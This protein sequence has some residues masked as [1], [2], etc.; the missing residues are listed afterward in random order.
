MMIARSFRLARTAL[1]MAGLVCLTTVASAGIHDMVCVLMPQ[2]EVPPNGSPN[3]TGAGVFKIDTTANT[4]S[5]YIVVGGLSAAETAAHIHGAAN[6]GVNAGVLQPLAVGTVKTGVWNYAQ[7][8][9]ADILAG[10]MYVN[11]H[12]TAFPGGEVRGQIVTHVA[13]LDSAQE[14]PANPSTARG[15]GLITLDK[16]AKTLSYYIVHNVAG[17]TAAHFHGFA[18]HGVNAGVSIAL[19]VGSPKVGVAPYVA[20]DEDK[21][22]DGL[23]YINIHSGAF[24]GGEI[25]GQLCHTILPHDGVQET[26]PNA[27]TAVGVGYIAIDR[28]TDN[29]S[30]DFR[31]TGLNTAETA[32]HIHGFAPRAVAAGVIHPLAVGARKL[33]VWNYPAA[34]EGQIVTGRTYANFHSSNFPGGE[35]RGQ[36]SFDCSRIGDTNGDNMVNFADLNSVL[37]SFGQVGGGLGGDVN[38]DGTCNFT[39]LNLTLSGFGQT[40]S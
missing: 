6:P 11:V 21:I 25:R 1:T 38:G 4:L 27:T 16:A 23:F 18:R 26:P 14:V 2:Q 31:H 19:P 32:A 40:C 28:A 8:Q 30:Y 13:D 12:T 7:A 17:E 39:D 37:S 15:F 35:V 34:N 29:L 3:A 20:A 22:L 24:P 10:R 5:Y 36:I 33:G 9:E